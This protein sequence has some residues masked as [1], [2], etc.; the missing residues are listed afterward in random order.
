MEYIKT[1]WVNNSTPVNA[2]N[3]N[4]IEDCLESLVNAINDLSDRVAALEN[5]SNSE[6]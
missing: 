6:E 1:E 5:N 3:L 2:D 4:K